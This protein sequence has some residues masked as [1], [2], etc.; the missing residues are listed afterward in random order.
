MRT[1][2]VPTRDEVSVESQQLFDAL[3]KKL[4]M[5][6]NL[7][8]SIGYSGNALASYLTFQDAQAQGTFNAK[9]REAV[10]LVVSQVNGCT[11]CQAAHTTL[12][13]MNG[14]TEEETIALRQGRSSDAKLNAIV[15]LAKSL[16]ENRGRASE[17]KV[18][19]FLAQ[20]YDQAALVDLVALVAS[21]TLANYVHNLFDFAIDFPE[22]Q[23]LEEAINA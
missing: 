10:N 5:V 2:N 22:A 20:G 18:E 11:Y 23:P 14:F 9:Q 16:V 4:G 3:E 8:A 12:G 13:K 6:P 21:K 1:F 15:G 19:E 17:D 7:Y